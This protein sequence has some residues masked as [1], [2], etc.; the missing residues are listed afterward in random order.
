MSDDG[1]K[2]F[3]DSFQLYSQFGPIGIIDDTHIGILPGSTNGIVF[4]AVDSS[5]NSGKI[6]YLNWTFVYLKTSNNQYISTTDTE[7]ALPNPPMTE[8]RP[9]NLRGDISDN[10]IQYEPTYPYTE[11]ALDTEYDRLMYNDPNS[12]FYI[13]SIYMRTAPLNNLITHRFKVYKSDIAAKKPAYIYDVAIPDSIELVFTMVKPGTTISFVPKPLSSKPP[14][15][16]PTPKPKPGP[17][18]K[19]KPTPGPGPTPGP[20]PGPYNPL[21]NPSKLKNN[22]MRNIIIA[23]IFIVFLLI[24]VGIF[25][26]VFKKHRRGNYVFT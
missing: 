16:I 5:V 3:T 2:L 4:T 21:P 25:I 11:G 23:S 14:T 13:R 17:G 7:L 6:F 22:N 18:P 19:P 9:I 20:T 8:F 1:I 26:V 10:L 24:L 12:V 15:P